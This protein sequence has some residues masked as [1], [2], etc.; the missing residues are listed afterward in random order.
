MVT[1]IQLVKDI[2]PEIINNVR[3]LAA[4]YNASRRRFENCAETDAAYVN[5]L[6]AL[7]TGDVGEVVN[8]GLKL[9]CFEAIRPVDESATA[10]HEA[11]YKDHYSTL[12][13]ISTCVNVFSKYV[14]PEWVA[15]FNTFWLELDMAF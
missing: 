4:M 2:D 7:R 15:K 10:L 14:T 9:L 11:G 5:L 12:R 6:K 8:H 3:T 13:D 1:Q